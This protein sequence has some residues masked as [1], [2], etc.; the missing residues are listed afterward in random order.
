MSFAE[1]TIPEMLDNGTGQM[2]RTSPI[3]SGQINVKCVSSP[4]NHWG[5]G[6]WGCTIRPE[7]T[8]AERPSKIAAM[9]YYTRRA[10][11]VHSLAS[12]QLVVNYK[13]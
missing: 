10:T 9:I 13:E 2:Y 11:T 7:R 1:L 3:K 12:L 5:Y 6:N 8:R 4:T